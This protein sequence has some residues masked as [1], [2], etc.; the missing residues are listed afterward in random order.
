MKRKIKGLLVL[1]FVFTTHLF[2]AQERAISGIVSDV[3][4]PIPGANVVVK[5]TSNGVQSD[6]DGKYSIKA[7]TGDVL[8]FSYMGMKDNAVTVRTASVINIKLQEDGKELDEVVVVAYGTA[9]KTSYTGS[10]A[11]IKSEQLE[12]RPLTN[13]LSVLEGSTSG[14]QIQSSGGQPGSAPE[15]RVRGFSSIN[16]SNT[17]LY[18]VDGVP[19]AGDI[20]NLNS[21]DIESLTVLKDASSI[22]LWFK[23]SKWSNYNYY[24]S[25][26]VGQR[27]IYIKHEY[28]YDFA[29]D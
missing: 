27:Q 7:K 2:F 4:G 20:S 11:Q 17:P 21:N 15:I 19:Y 16:G 8:V 1:V 29:L 18:I 12:S 5:G 14:V 28:R 9:K 22:T 26:K 23:S 13:A 24:K 10:A 25:R 3:A 6:F